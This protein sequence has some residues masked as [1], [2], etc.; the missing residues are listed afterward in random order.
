MHTALHRLSIT[1]DDVSPA[2]HRDL[3]VPSNLRLDQ[4]HQVLQTVMGW[5]DS[6]LHMFI[7]ESGQDVLRYGA[8][9]PDF[10]DFGM[11]VK[12]ENRYTLEQLA[13]AA[14]SGFDYWYD[15]GDDWHHS[16]EVTAVMD[17]A[18]LEAG[19]GI[20]CIAAQGACPPEDCGGPPGYAHLL[21]CLQNPKHPEHRDARQWVGGTFDPAFV[22]LEQINRNLA[23]LAAAFTAA[24]KA[25]AKRPATRRSRTAPVTARKSTARATAAPALM[26]EP[27]LA[28]KF[29]TH[30]QNILLDIAGPPGKRQNLIEHLIHARDLLAR[31]PER[32]AAT[33]ER[34]RGTDENPHEDVVNALQDFRAQRWIYLRDTRSHSIFL[35]PDGSAAYGVL[36]LTQRIR[37]ISQGSGVVVN[38][39]LLNFRG[40]IICDGL[41]ATGATL[42]PGIRRDYTAQLAQARADGRYSTTALFPRAQGD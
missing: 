34:L 19:E 8:P 39:A 31:E 13:P 12:A 5:D 15:F 1:L 23:A 18:S 7:V 14:G 17:A 11:P 35:E 37:E 29:I 26:L 24:R 38:A 36:G 21:E 25:H 2:V 41:I 6:H 16:I 20:H 22:D 30:Y 9:D 40:C 33:L 3:V 28:S 42:G 27:L 4:L 10:E 32:L